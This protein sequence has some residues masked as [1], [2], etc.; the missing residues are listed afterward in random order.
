V[1]SPAAERAACA[2]LFWARLPRRS[3]DAIAGS[4]AGLSDPDRAEVVGLLEAGTL[5]G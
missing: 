2:A 1:T 5:D 3:D 4:V